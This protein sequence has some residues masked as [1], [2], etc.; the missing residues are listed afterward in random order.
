MNLVIIGSGAREHAIALRVS[1]SSRKPTI[2]CLA[3][4]SNPGI[5]R[6]AAGYEILDITDRTAVSNQCRQWS[7]TLA[8]IGPE[9]PLEA[10]VADTLRSEGVLV[11]GP[12]MESAKIETSKQFARDLLSDII[13]E[14]SP[15]YR[16]VSNKDQA[17]SFL[18][19]LGEDYVIKAD[20]L[21][22]GKGVKVSG[23]HLHSHEQA[24]AYVDELLSADGK[25]IIEQ[26]LIGQEFSLFTVTD[27]RTS[28]HLPPIQDHKRILEGDLGA[29]T[30]GMGSYSDTGGSLPF[31]SQHDVELA[32]TYNEKVIQGLNERCGTPYRG[33][34][35]GGFMATADGVSIIEF[36]A[37]FGDPEVMNLM[38]I[39]TS[40]MLELILG[41]ASG[42]LDQ[43]RVDTSGNA[44]VCTYLVPEGYPHKSVK[45][46]QIVLGAIPPSVNIFFG[47][48]N[49]NEG[50]LTTA[51]SRT[52]ACCATG[53]TIE[54]AYQ[55]VQEA[56]SLI[57][58]PLHYRKD[59]GSR[60]LIRKRVEMMR[61]L[62]S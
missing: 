49:E 34:L 15:T 59:I 51:G 36:N 53:D 23:D 37:R 42:T 8:V 31:L 47:S 14:A 6:L 9:A 11:F 20:G 26:R 1:Q 25:C 12:D 62:R 43:V 17:A 45:G 54:Q 52:L 58:G 30:G 19:E 5:R 32:K 40:D 41:A 44:S 27:G 24:L 50:V 10:G 61:S 28:I 33:V 13:P 3:T 21:A 48:V 18:I 35:Y 29:N 22:G 46:E 56:A 7:I 57:E 55:L 2:Y 16:V 38:M 4:T 39:I 60:D